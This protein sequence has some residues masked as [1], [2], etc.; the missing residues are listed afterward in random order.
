MSLAK[1]REFLGLGEEAEPADGS[2]SGS[3][4]YASSGWGGGDEG[5]SDA[6]GAEDD[7]ERGWGGDAGHP[8]EQQEWEQQEAAEVQHE[9]QQAAE[10]GPA[11]EE[12]GQPLGSARL[13][14]E[15]AEVAVSAMCACR[16]AA[17]ALVRLRAT[18]HAEL[19]AAWVLAVHR[20][21][22]APAPEP[23]VA[24]CCPPQVRRG[25]VGAGYRARLCP[26]YLEG[27]ACPRGDG[28]ADAHSQRELRVEAA[29]AVGSMGLVLCKG[30]ECAACCCSLHVASVC[31]GVAPAACGG[32]MAR[33][34]AGQ[35]QANRRARAPAIRCLRPAC[36]RP[37][38]SCACAE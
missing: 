38:T 22:T 35:L 25:L 6:W 13:T 2:S 15:E 27:S 23:R 37:T 16:A 36:C 32:C 30:G 17:A 18:A 9:D 4:S 20:P 19:C 33:R 21:L 28:C 24:L 34:R 5:G 26:H 3:D 12:E 11:G 1:A 31:A 7:E 14:V 10:E 29:I 8:G